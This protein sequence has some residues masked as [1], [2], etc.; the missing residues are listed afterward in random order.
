MERL[1]LNLVGNAIKYRS[2]SGPHRIWIDLTELGDEWRVSV[3][4][5][6]IGIK[7]EF[8]QRVFEIF[9]RVG[10][11]SKYD[12]TGIGLA[13]CQK[14]VVAHGGSIGVD[15]TPGSGSEFWFM[16]P[17][18]R[19]LQAEIDLREDDLVQA[20]TSSGSPS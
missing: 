1:F 11:R 7:P 4:D 5:N 18:V 12:G 17:R 2:E 13:V 3:R 9:K 14:I 8:H 15:S 19:E 6:G 16:L 10:S 20:L